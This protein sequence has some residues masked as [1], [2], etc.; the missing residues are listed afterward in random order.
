[1][2]PNAQAYA[3]Y[4]L[5]RAG[6][7]DAGRVRYFQDTDGDKLVGALARGHLAAALTLVGVAIARNPNHAEDEEY[8]A[9]APE[10][11]PEP[12]PEPSSP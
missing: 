7:A 4:V 10:P 9:A 6:L 12:T 1:M 11:A 3:W 8:L 2:T 5:A